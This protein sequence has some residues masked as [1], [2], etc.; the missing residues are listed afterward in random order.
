M[1]SGVY[2]RKS[3]DKLAKLLLGVKVLPNGCWLWLKSKNSRGYGQTNK[4]YYGEGLAHRAVYCWSGFSL[5]PTQVLR[6]T[7]DTPSCVNPGHLIAGTQ[8]ANIRDAVEKGVM[9][10]YT[11]TKKDI[12]TIR[13]LHA[14]GKTQCSIASQFAVSQ[15][16]VSSILTGVRQNVTS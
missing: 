5:S 16:V 15:Q 13:A 12:D 6:H 3:T 7:C 11:L 14:E 1:T 10:G 2:V 8:A 4:R 9:K